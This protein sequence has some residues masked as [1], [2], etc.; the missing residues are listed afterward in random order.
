MLKKLLPL[1]LALALLLTACGPAA[2]I[3]SQPED[4]SLQ[5]VATTYPVYLFAQEVTRNADNVTVTCMINQAVGCLHD[6]TLSI[7]DMKILD[8]ADLL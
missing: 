7:K 4:D 5:V 6:Y 8:R 1:V 2:Q 3:S